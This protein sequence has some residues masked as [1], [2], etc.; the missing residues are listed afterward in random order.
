MTND[1]EPPAQEAAPEVFKGS[2]RRQS[3]TTPHATA[4]LLLDTAVEFLATV[5][6][7]QVTTTMIVER[8]GVSYGSL[9]HHYEDIS[10]LV[11]QA[12]VYVYTRRLK[13]SVQAMRGLLDASDAADFRQRS[14]DLIT[15]S[16]SP[17]MRKNRLE[18]VEAIGAMQGR[19]RLVARI[20]KAQQE[21]TDEA[22]AVVKEYQ[23]R[24]W[25]R[26]DLDPVAVAAYLQVMT[27]GRVVDDIAERPIDRQ[28]WNDVALCAFC[29]ILFAD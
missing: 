29:A 18:R 3:R 21:I 24:G 25:A 15:R 16:I 27:V 9:Y 26:A 10:D 7:D 2:S 13:E 19:P 12:V 8:S 5:S 4:T 1:H 22:G 28:V 23:E 20:A 6:V 14:E 17:E 11:E